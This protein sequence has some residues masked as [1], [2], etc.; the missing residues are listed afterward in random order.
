MNGKADQKVA[1]SHKLRHTPRKQRREEHATLRARAIQTYLLTRIEGMTQH[2]A[3]YRTHPAK[4]NKIS[5]RSAARMANREIE[6]VLEHCG[7]EVKEVQRLFRLDVNR[8]CYELDRQLEAT[9][10]TEFVKTEVL[11][12]ECG[13]PSG[14][15]VHKPF[16]LTLRNTVQVPDNVTRLKAT[17]ILYDLL[18]AAQ[19]RKTSE[20]TPR[21]VVVRNASTS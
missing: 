3:Y 13:T 7:K 5:K 15:L 20:P 17:K 12:H 21:T 19:Y 6:F 18:I 16:V 11:M 9:K 4:R 10:L 2:E 1:K 14:E 8:L